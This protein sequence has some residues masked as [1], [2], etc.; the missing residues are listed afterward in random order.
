MVEQKFRRSA[1]L[2]INHHRLLFSIGVA[3]LAALAMALVGWGIWRAF[4]ADG[5]RDM[6]W[7]GAHLLV[8]GLDPSAVFEACW[9]TSCGQH[10]IILSQLPNYPIS[11][12]VMFMPIGAL[13]WPTAKLAWSLVNLVSI[14][15]LLWALR[16]HLAATLD[17]RSF[18]VISLGFL[19]STPLRNQIE[20]GQLGLFSI[21]MLA[22]ALSAVRRKHSI[23]AGMLLALALMKFTLTLPLSL[24][25]VARREWST[26]AVA[27]ALHLA[28]TGFAALWTHTDPVALMF[29]FLRVTRHA[30]TPDAGY[31]DLVALSYHLGLPLA[32]PLGIVTVLAGISVYLALRVN[33]QDELL[34]LSVTSILALTMFFHLSYDCVVLIFPAVYLAQFF[35]DAKFSHKECV[36][37][38]SVLAMIVITWFLQ[39]V[40]ELATQLYLPSYRLPSILALS[41][42]LYVASYLALADGLRLLWNARDR[43]VHR[44]VES[45]SHT[46]H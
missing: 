40:I 46:M 22:L 43:F 45:Q 1:I 6:Q 9:P 18:L 24:V 2:V 19:I 35:E 36:F 33:A 16:D 27:A 10:G 30:I 38:F 26:L 28:A 25:F 8:Q 14:A 20:N 17:R 42:L 39:K 31:V 32:L 4:A 7:S 44:H 11:A 29:G 12:L 23:W 21:A 15:V 34:L 3:I 37:A 5:S 13:P 41:I